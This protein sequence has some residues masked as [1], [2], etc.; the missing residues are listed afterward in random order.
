MDGGIGKNINVISDLDFH[1]VLRKVDWSMLPEFLG[2]HVARTRS[3][4]ERVRHL[5]VVLQLNL[6]GEKGKKKCEKKV[7]Q[8]I[9]EVQNRE[10][11]QR[12]QCSA[13]AMAAIAVIEFKTTFVLL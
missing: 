9:A 7:I 3:G 13:R 11:R 2:K 10:N 6:E 5:V 12:V 1:Q 8:G 4:S